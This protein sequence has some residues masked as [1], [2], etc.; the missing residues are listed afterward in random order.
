MMNA[1]E[2][3]SVYDTI[4]SI[5]GMNDQIKIDLKISRRNVLLLTQAIKRALSFPGVE[6]NPDLIE[7]ASNETKEELLAL[8]ADCL[9]K[10]GLVELNKRLAKL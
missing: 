8:S 3:T 5:S 10:S 6:G 9:Q 4:M 2:L 7:I 1:K